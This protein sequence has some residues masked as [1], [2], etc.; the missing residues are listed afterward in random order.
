MDT[1]GGSTVKAVCDRFGLFA[2]RIKIYKDDK[3]LKEIK[4]GAGEMKG[5]RDL[6]GLAE[7]SLNT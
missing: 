5:F 3:C 7:E 4:L 6:L 2:Q 1:E